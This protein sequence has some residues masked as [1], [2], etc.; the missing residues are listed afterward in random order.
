MKPAENYR[1]LAEEE[2]SLAGEAFSNESRAQHYAMAAYYTRL[3]DAKERL[4]ITT[5]VGTGEAG[6]EDPAPLTK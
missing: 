2:A 4:A 1:R 6:S 3:A 5:E